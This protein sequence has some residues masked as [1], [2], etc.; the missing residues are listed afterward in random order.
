MKSLQ[1]CVQVIKFVALQ[2]GSQKSSPLS[3]LGAEAKTEAMQRAVIVEDFRNRVV[4]LSMTPG[5]KKLA[6]SGVTFSAMQFVKR[7]AST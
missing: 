3:K 5:L 7:P 6:Q 2:A 1:L 4:N